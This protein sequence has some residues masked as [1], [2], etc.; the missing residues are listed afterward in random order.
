MIEWL[1]DPP[2]LAAVSTV[3]LALFAALQVGLEVY[4]WR[5]SR[6]AAR[7]EARGPAWLAR[8]SLE[9]SLFAAEKYRDVLNWRRQAAHGI[10]AA[11]VQ[12]QMLETLRVGSL[13][14]GSTARHAANAFESYL[15][16]ADRMG[17]LTRFQPSAADEFGDLV[18]TDKDNERAHRL[19]TDAL[20]HCRAAIGSLAHLA[21]RQPHEPSIPGEVR[22]LPPF[23]TSN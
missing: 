16:F 1:R 22:F 4:R 18:M 5:Q 17:A 12:A 10:D 11:E 20:D 19:A 7:I 9:Q 3:L 14:G 8:R 2:R 6:K 21:P 23:H 15:A 13:A